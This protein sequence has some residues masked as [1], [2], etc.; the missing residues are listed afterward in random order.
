M[1]TMNKY[2]AAHIHPFKPV[3]LT[4]KEKAT[5]SKRRA[6]AGAK[7]TNKGTTKRKRRGKKDDD[8]SDDNN[9]SPT[10]KK[11]RPKKPGL[12][13]PY[14]LSEELA[15]VVGKDVLPRPQVV[16]AIWDYIKSNDL[17]VSTESINQKNMK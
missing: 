13:P 3:D 15:E 6:P 16:S 1:F 8:D 7:S 9:K 11:R 10:K 4:P 12:Q 5:P 2:V 14:R 17:Q